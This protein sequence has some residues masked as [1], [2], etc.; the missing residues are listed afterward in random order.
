MISIAKIGDV[1]LL[2]KNIACQVVDVIEFEGNSY[3]YLIELENN[4]IDSIKQKTQKFHFVE[5][6]INEKEDY[7]IKNITD[8]ELINNLKKL[9]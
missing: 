9:I 7:F 5:E 1:L 6:M 4:L 2:E 8:S 3:L